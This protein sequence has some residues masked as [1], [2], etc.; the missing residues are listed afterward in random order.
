MID[1]PRQARDKQRENSKQAGRVLAGQPAQVR[2]ALHHRHRRLQA[3]A[4]LQVSE[5]RPSFW[6][7]FLIQN[8]HDCDLSRQA[9]DKMYVYVRKLTPEGPFRF[10][11]GTL[12][13]LTW[14][15]A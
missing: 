9:W 13:A 8:D 7:D 2:D 1:L 14:S 6:R 3:V 4:V 5:F 10:R 15:F 11:F 12:S